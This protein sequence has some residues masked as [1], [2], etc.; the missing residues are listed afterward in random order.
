MVISRSFRVLLGSTLLAALSLSTACLGADEG[1]VPTDCIDNQGR[2]YSPCRVFRGRLALPLANKLLLPQK[3]FQVA[4]VAFER[5]GNQPAVD[6]GTGAATQV[7]PRFFFGDVFTYTAGA[8]QRADYPFAIVVPCRLA[9]NL[10]LQ[11]PSSGTTNLPGSQVA[12]MSFAKDDSGTLT[13]LIPPQLGDLCGGTAS[14]IDLE[15]VDLVVPSD[16]DLSGS[17]ITL[18]VGKSRNPLDIL[19]TDGDGQVDSADGDDDDDGLAD[20]ADEDANGDGIAD[21][22]QLLS[23]LPDRDKNGRPDL[24]E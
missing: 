19:D 22:V 16:K 17:S 8:G 18:G 20:V 2:A 15:A 4:A 13:T 3:P 5:S 24:F 10:L 7:A 6:G 11:V 14:S 1:G 9:V 23:A 21:S 12:P